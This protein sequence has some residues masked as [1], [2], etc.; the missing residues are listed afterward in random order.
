MIRR[1]PRSTLF[2][3]TTLF[4][5]RTVDPVDSVAFRIQ[6]TQPLDPRR[7]LDTARVRLYALPDTTPVAV[8]ALFTPPQYDSIQAKARAA[9]DSA[10]RAADTAHARRDTTRAGAAPPP[11]AGRRAPPVA[12]APSAPSG[13]DT[14]AVRVD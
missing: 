7:P 12:G 13:R 10:R 14:G 3:Y 9:A 5:S 6:F 11:P 1:P 8:R 4:R 2:P